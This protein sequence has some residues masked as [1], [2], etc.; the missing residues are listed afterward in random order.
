MLYDR[1]G[2]GKWSFL[3]MGTWRYQKQED[4]SLCNVPFNSGALFRIL[5][6]AGVRKP[7]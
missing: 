4:K 5:S 6:M 3:K 2:E 7:I 1:A